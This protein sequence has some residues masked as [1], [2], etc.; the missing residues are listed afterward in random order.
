MLRFL[1]G[2]LQSGYRVSINRN[3][4]STQLGVTIA[5]QHSL[6]NWSMPSPTFVDHRC[7]TVTTQ[8]L[9]FRFQHLAASVCSARNGLSKDVA[10][11]VLS[12]YRVSIEYSALGIQLCSIS[13]KREYAQFDINRQAGISR[14]CNCP[15]HRPMKPIELVRTSVNRRSEGPKAECC[16]GSRAI[17]SV[18]LFTV[19]ASGIQI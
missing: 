13:S 11:Q 19:N 10:M 3:I 4:F 16:K 8:L 15:S 14:R 5:I 18:S 9:A 12:P 2:A 6:P 7:V 17:N 1:L